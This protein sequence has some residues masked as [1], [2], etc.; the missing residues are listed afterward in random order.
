MIVTTSLRQAQGT[1][2]KVSNR[3]TAGADDEKRSTMRREE[4]GRVRLEGYVS[5]LTG[6]KDDPYNKDKGYWKDR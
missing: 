2:A 5:K 4:P 1:A 6:N 3:Q